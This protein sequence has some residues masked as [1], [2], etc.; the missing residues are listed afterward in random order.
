MGKIIDSDKYKERR[1]E[2]EVDDQFLNDL[3]AL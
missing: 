3:R 1:N 2:E